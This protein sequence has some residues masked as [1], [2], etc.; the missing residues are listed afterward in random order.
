LNLENNRHPQPAASG[1]KVAL[2]AAAFGAVNIFKAVVQLLLLPVM[3]RLLGP[4]EFGLYALALPT[5]ALVA[6][7][8]DGGLGYTL[9]REDEASSLVWSSAFWVLLFLGLILA[10]GVSLF[11]VLLGYLSSEPRLP[12]IIAILSVSLI[13]L[14]I[15]V[16]PAARLIRRKNLGAGA[17][18]DLSG[19]IS[20]ALVAVVLAKN[21]AGAWSLALQY[22][23]TY[24]VRAIVLNFAAF[25]RPKAEFSFA[26]LSPHLMSGGILVT[27]RIVDYASRLAE[28]FV[29]NR[30]FGSIVLG[31]Y[32]FANQISRFSTEAISNVVWGALYAQALTGDRTKIP[33]LHR[34][35]CRMLGI[36]LFPSTFLAAAA[37]PELIDILLGPK[38]IDLSLYLRVL[39]PIFS[40]QV[41]CTQSVA[42]IVAYGRFDV[43]FWSSS[44]YG[45]GRVIAVCLAPWIGVSGTIFAIGFV[46]LVYCLVM[47]IVASWL[48]KCR[49]LPFLRGLAAPALSAAIGTGSY[50]LLI[51]NDPAN[52][53]WIV[54][55]LVA[56]LAV[57]AACMLLIDRK[58]LFYDWKSIRDLLAGRQVS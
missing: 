14:T 17:G 45:L 5:I 42:V 43:Q 44:G 52:R 34:R 4:A 58:T 16:V 27:S 11:G 21:G 15:S 30:V 2:G 23:T 31:N 28:N 49:A 55:S 13:F 48:A 24:V 9:A 41:I 25:H 56:G 12:P 7:L 32:T 36:I 20:G 1:R 18:A 6:L 35:L 37:A 3:A 46:T 50:L 26:A 54:I 51:T 22:V 57:Y 53:V 10:A 19:V 39:L 8:S 38:W 29:I 33:I 47:L 40:L